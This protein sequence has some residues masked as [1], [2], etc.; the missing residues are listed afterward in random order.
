MHATDDKDVATEHALIGT[1]NTLVPARYASTHMHAAWPGII[2][3]CVCFL[4]CAP[5]VMSTAHVMAATIS[6]TDA[7]VL[8][9]WLHLSYRH[10]TADNMSASNTVTHG[11][12]LRSTR[13]HVKSEGFVKIKYLTAYHIESAASVLTVD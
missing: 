9:R 3:F 5:R 13:C 1:D 8:M 6:S 12:S 10:N 11:L 4:I 2:I 7:I